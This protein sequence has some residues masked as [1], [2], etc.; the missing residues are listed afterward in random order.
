MVG[1]KTGKERDGIWGNG[2]CTIRKEKGLV[3]L[4]M[5][6]TRRGLREVS[7]SSLAERGLAQHAACKVG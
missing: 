1:W 3:Q 4:W 5:E 2:A 6:R 7:F